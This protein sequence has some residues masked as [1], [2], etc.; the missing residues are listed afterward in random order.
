MKLVERIAEWIWKGQEEKRRRSDLKE[1]ARELLEK[2]KAGDATG[3]G[4][5]TQHATTKAVQNVRE[6]LEHIAGEQGTV[7]RRLVEK[8]KP[9]ITDEHLSLGGGT[10]LAAR[11][12]HRESYDVDLFCQ[13]EVFARL[14]PETRQ[15][16]E[17]RIKQSPGSEKDATWCE[18]LGVYTE[19]DGIEATVLPRAGVMPE[20]RSTM[21]EG[22]G[23]R[24]Q[25]TEEIL[26]GKIVNRMYEGGEIALRDAYDIA[27]AYLQD[28]GALE[29]AVKRIDERSVNDVIATLSNL[30]HGWTREMQQPLVGA[31]YEWGEEELS[32]RA[33][34][35]LMW[36]NEERREVEQGL[37]R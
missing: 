13:P 24:L 27:C 15:R 6:H 12:K 23:V 21:L 33:I 14:D 20:R 5:D 37:D 28:R 18:D 34:A 11:W 1:L 17:E 31:K 32:T 8:L 29:R 22:T 9:D 4:T 3:R 30:P 35:A 2:E 36:A 19:I 7:A 10:V 25:A 16:I 26:Y